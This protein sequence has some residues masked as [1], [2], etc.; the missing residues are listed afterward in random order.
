[1]QWLGKEALRR[2]IKNKP[3][4]GGFASVEE[5]TFYVR[6]C[7]GLGLLDHDDA[8]EDVLEDNEFVE[9]G[10][11]TAHYRSENTLC[12]TKGNY[13]FHKLKWSKREKMAGNNIS[14]SPS[15]TSLPLN[16]RYFSYSYFQ[17]SLK[18]F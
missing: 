2:Y 7:K 12:T 9:V 10:K 5:I 13:T 18:H 1:M 14:W 11:Q 15:G 3:D 17:I 8:L 4:N 16:I 6:C